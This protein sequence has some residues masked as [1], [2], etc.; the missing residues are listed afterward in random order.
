MGNIADDALMQD[1][2]Q[3]L[4]FFQVDLTSINPSYPITYWVQS[5]N[6]TVSNGVTF[7]SPVVWTL[8]Y[9]LGST[10]Q[11]IVWNPIDLQ[12]E[13][14]ESTSQGTLPRPRI[15]FSN[16]LGIL[17]PAIVQYGDLVGGTLRRFRTYGKYLDGQPNAS[18]TAY[19]GPDVRRIE[20]KTALNN[21]VAEFE[22]ASWMD[23]Q[24]IMLPYRVV[25][26]DYC[27]ARYRIYQNGAWN[28]SQSQCPYTGP[29]STPWAASTAYTLGQLIGPEGNF[30]YQCTTAGKS[31]S[32]A[33]TWN[34]TLEGSTTD[35]TVTWETVTGYWDQFG[36]PTTEAND[37]CGK[38]LSDC[39]LRFSKS[40]PIPFWGFLGCERID[41]SG[42]N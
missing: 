24:N 30:Y 23:Q 36:N 9:P 27:L 32:T 25:I 13:D 3:V 14:W 37:Q 20:R 10:P 42:G 41:T 17:T 26:R 28:Y 35:G 8:E 6:E 34:T 15:R 39:Q 40:A 16:V 4:Q 33:P 38:R 31:G 2:G 29:T 12:L 7:T 19:Y 21:M 5:A 11:T 18:P 1:L 22:L